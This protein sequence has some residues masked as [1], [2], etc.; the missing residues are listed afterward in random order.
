MASKNDIH[1]Q[2]GVRLMEEH[3]FDSG[4][5]EGHRLT[6]GRLKI[7]RLE[8][9][10]GQLPGAFVE[11]DNT[12]LGDRTNGLG[13]TI[14]YPVY[15]FAEGRVF[16][17]QVVEFVQRPNGERAASGKWSWNGGTGA[18]DNIRGE[19]SVEAKVIHAP[20]GQQRR[21]VDYQGSYWFE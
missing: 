4:G 9:I 10:S 16:G 6:V 13:T 18:F 15:Q 3:G 12:A 8:V 1:F 20:D 17:R 5:V 14:A 7:E 2:C 21:V 19:G 11:G